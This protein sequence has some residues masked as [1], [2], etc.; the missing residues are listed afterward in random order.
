MYRFF[1][2]T[3]PPPTFER[4]QLTDKMDKENNLRKTILIFRLYNQQI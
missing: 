1:S 3:K 4:V 2:E